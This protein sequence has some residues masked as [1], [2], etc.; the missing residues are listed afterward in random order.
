MT[1]LRVS[2]LAA[3]LSASCAPAPVAPSP[4]PPPSSPPP[5]AVA[6]APS[7]PPADPARD[8][9]SKIDPI[10]A[11]YAK[12]GVPGCA[13]GVYRAGELLFAH[14]YGLA[15]LDYGVPIEKDTV[16]EAYSVS[17]QFTA[18]AIALLVGDGKVALD[19][20]VRKYVPE[21]PVYGKRPITLRDL[22]HH[23]SGLRDYAFLLDVAGF[24]QGDYTTDDDV[25]FLLTHQKA[26]NF[27]TGTKE[28]YSNSGYFLLSVVVKRVTGKSLGAFAKERLFD[29]LGMKHTFYLEDPSVVIPRRALGYAPKGDAFGVDMMKS[30]VV[31]ARGVQ[32]TI[33]DLALWDANFYDPK[34]G[35]AAF[36]QTMRTPGKLD[37]GKATTY[38]FGLWMGVKNG[39]AFEEHSGGGAGFRTELARYPAERLTIAC[40][41]NVGSAEPEALAQ[42]VAEVFLPKLKPSGPASEPPSSGTAP[43]LYAASLAELAPILGVYYAPATYEMRSISVKDGAIFLGYGLDPEGPRRPMVA[44]DARTLLVKPSQPGDSW[45]IMTRYTFLPAEGAHGARLVRAP[46][47]EKATTFERVDP[48][49]LS[50]SALAAYAGRYGSDEIR[51]DWWL[52]VTDGHLMAAKWGRPL[53]E[54]PLLPIARDMFVTDSHEF[55]HF[56]RDAR[57]KVHGF[58]YGVDSPDGIRWVRR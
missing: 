47:D 31:G 58:V 53:H 6:P 36:L 42:S 38:A 20:D 41:C 54:H 33:E 18:A 27:P 28:S 29:P 2:L 11:P 3:F 32:T 51:I 57:G 35:G 5:V 13:V 19:D 26:L 25:T 1:P 40:F 39:V 10:F 50:P 46:H 45:P 55:F 12:P 21:L 52:G 23:T 17:K 8:L 16:F 4:A 34:V 49:A 24:A 56:E 7:Q 9:A 22:V 14:G 44:S 30:E 43:H 48:T 37:D 15:N